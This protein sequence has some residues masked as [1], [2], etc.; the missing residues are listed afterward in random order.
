MT[1]P[2]ALLGPDNREEHLTYPLSNASRRKPRRSVLDSFKNADEYFLTDPDGL[3]CCGSS[4]E[5]STQVCKR[6]L[7]RFRAYA[8]LPVAIVIPVILHALFTTLVVWVDRNINGNL[9]LPASI[10]LS[11]S[12]SIVTFRLY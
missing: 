12:S 10:V 4:R 7:L 8:H 6:S 1:V 11:P 3:S 5:L 2:G 9:G